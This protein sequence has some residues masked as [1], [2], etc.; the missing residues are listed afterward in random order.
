MH[1]RQRRDERRRQESGAV[2]HRARQPRV[3]AHG[4]PD[5]R[6]LEVTRLDHNL[7][8]IHDAP[9]ARFS[10]QRYR[11]DGR[12]ADG[13]PRVLEIPGRQ[14]R[15]AGLGKDVTDKFL[16]GL[17]GVQKEGCD[18]II[19]SARFILHRMPKAIRTVCLEYFGQVRDSVPSIVEIKDYLDA[20]PVAILAGLEHLDERYLKAVGYATKAASRWESGPAEDGADRRHRRRRRGRGRAR[21]L[22]GRAPR[23]RPRRRRVRRGVGRDAQEVLARP[24]AHRGHREAHQRVQD[25][26]GRRHSARAARRL[27]RRHRADQRRAVDREQARAARRAGRVL[28][29]RPAAPPARRE[30]ARRGAARRPAGAGAGAARECARTVAVPA[31]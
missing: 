28:P 8:K 9:V 24:R 22:G 6:W 31:G 17:P 15:K 26:R 29:G 23:E 1:R 13:A 19:T 7:G 5:G 30:A 3:V 16:A 21:D 2:G 14:F 11:R 10:I 25:Q 12:T 27:L 18:G 20:H 4:H